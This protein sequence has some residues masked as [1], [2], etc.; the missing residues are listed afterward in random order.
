MLLL[1][2]FDGTNIKMIILKAYILLQKF[3]WYIIL[4]RHF[5]SKLV[6]AVARNLLFYQL[7]GRTA[8]LHLYVIIYILIYSSTFDS[9][10]YGYMHSST[11]MIFV[12]IFTYQFTKIFITSPNTP[13][14]SL[15]GKKKQVYF[16]ISYLMIG[17][18][19]TLF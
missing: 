9:P 6:Q 13:F 5:E 3:S 11:F 16:I 8:F 18:H 4:W 19:F 14:L 15:C 10:I 7:R 17:P 12:Y 1:L 2:N